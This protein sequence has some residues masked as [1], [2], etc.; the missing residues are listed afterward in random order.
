MAHLRPIPARLILV[1]ARCITLKNA[2]RDGRRACR[3]V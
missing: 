1:A 2:D 3:R